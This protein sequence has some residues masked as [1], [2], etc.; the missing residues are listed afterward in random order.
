MGKIKLA[1][2]DDHR[3]FR[4]GIITIMGEVPEFE[5][6]VEAEN[7]RVLLDKLSHIKVDV[8]LLDLD[9][10]EMNGTATLEVLKRQSNS[11]AVIILSMHEEE[12]MIISMV[13]KGAKGYLFKNADPDEVENAIFSVARN[14]FYFNDKVSNAMLNKV[15]ATDHLTTQFEENAQFTDR[16]MEVLYLIGQELTNVEIAER[17]HLSR[18]TVEGHRKNM[19]KKIDARNTAGLVIYAVKK[20]IL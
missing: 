9:M 7:G 20:G 17:L 15:V 10:P 8:I 12:E 3:L 16:E 19:L 4:Q 18:R 1:I 6:L 2:A 5:F 11:P 13:E 14:G